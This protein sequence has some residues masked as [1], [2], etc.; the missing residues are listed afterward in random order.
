MS[1]RVQFS[2]TD[3]QN[4]LQNLVLN[5]VMFTAYD[6][7]K[8]LRSKDLEAIHADVRDQVH[9]FMAGTLTNPI[10]VRTL[11]R[12]N[13]YDPE[14]YVYHP[15]GTDVNTY[16]SPS[17]I[18]PIVSDLEKVKLPNGWDDGQVK[19]VADHYDSLKQSD[20][21]NM[22][23]KTIS[24]RS[25]SPSVQPVLVPQKTVVDGSKVSLSPEELKSLDNNDP[26]LI[27]SALDKI[28]CL[29]N[30]CK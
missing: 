19:R 26:E 16:Q 23:G 12:F 11:R 24:K 13:D 15:Q 14:A 17:Q 2:N 8:Q 18:T 22:A 9:S 3:L 30:S 6:V 25:A 4:V 21:K 29:W 10:Y 7:T 28:S 20:I 5:Q 1:N 27:S